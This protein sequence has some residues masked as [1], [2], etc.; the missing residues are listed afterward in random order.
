M[1]GQCAQVRVDIALEFMQQ[2]QPFGLADSR[3]AG[4][5]DGVE[6]GGAEVAQHAGGLAEDGHDRVAGLVAAVPPHAEA[7]PASA[8]GSRKAV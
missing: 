2:R 8:A 7:G 3:R 5:F 4:E 6:H 1:A